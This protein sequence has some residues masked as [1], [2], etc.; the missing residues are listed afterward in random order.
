MA[1]KLAVG[2]VVEL[3]SGG[4]LMTVVKDRVEEGNKFVQVSWFAGV[5]LRK[6]VLPKDA[7][8]VK[9][10]VVTPAAQGTPAE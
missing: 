1:V 6:E 3:R 4:P 5:E 8:T 2:V 10:E 9:A 7:L